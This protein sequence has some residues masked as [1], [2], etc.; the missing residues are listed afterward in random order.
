MGLGVNHFAK[1]DDV[2]ARFYDTIEFT[3]DDGQ[4]RWKYGTSGWA[5]M[6]LEPVEAALWFSSKDDRQLALRSG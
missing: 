5:G 4:S 3:F 1:Q 6:P 2:V